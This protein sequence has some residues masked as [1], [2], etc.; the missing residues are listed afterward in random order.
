MTKYR[1]KLT[2]SPEA[3]ARHREAMIMK[4]RRPRTPITEYRTVVSVAKPNHVDISTRKLSEVGWPKGRR[5][6]VGVKDGAILLVPHVGGMYRS[7]RF[8]RTL[9]SRNVGW[10]PGDRVSIHVTPEIITIERVEK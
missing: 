1:L 7:G 6:N 9:A 4:R 3:Y 5:Y 10:E 2:M 8:I